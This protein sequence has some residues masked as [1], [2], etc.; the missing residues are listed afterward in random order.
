MKQ[1]RLFLLL[2][3]LGFVCIPYNTSALGNEIASCNYQF[4][5]VSGNQI[6]LKYQVLSDGSV[7]LPFGDGENY[8]N[9]NFS[10]YHSEQFSDKFYD[11]FSIDENTVT[12]PSI[13]VQ[14]NESGFTVYPYPLSSSVCTGNCYQAS[15]LPKL[16]DSAKKSGIK[17]KKVVSSCSGSSMGFYNR[18]SYVYPYFRLFS[19]GTKEWSIDGAT[20]VPVSEAITGSINSSEKFSISVNDSLIDSIFSSNSLTCPSSIYRCV[21]RIQGGYSYELSTSGNM[22]S[23]DTL[24]TEDGQQLGSNYANLG[25]GD[26]NNGSNNGNVTLDDLKEDLNSYNQSTTCNGILGK[27]GDEESVAWLL[28]QILNYIKIL[29]PIL[30]V[31]LSSMD[32]AKAIIA[33]DDESMKKAEKKLMIRLVLAVALF[34]VPTLVSV[35]LN[36]LGYTADGQLCLLK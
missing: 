9:T 2:F 32:F 33:S 24:S 23:N 29:G 19:D 28:Q 8:N 4:T 22:C 5:D 25:Y 15:A 17:S 7:K 31:I 3:I 26:P 36:V 27:P 13:F 11:A 10:W 21:N 20:Y 30:V 12:C 6:K 16:S 34:L 14:Q 35:M 18:Q 1:L